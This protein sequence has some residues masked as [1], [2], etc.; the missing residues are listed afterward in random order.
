MKGIGFSLAVLALLSSVSCAHKQAEQN[1]HALNI[2]VGTYTDNNESQGVY[3]YQFDTETAESLLLDTARS[4][5]PSFIITSEDG[6]FAYAVNEYM[7]SRQGVSSFIL[8]D[9][10]VDLLNYVQ[11][12]CAGPC[13]I[14]LA[15]G[16]V[17]TA[18]YGG[19]TLSVFPVLEDGS[20]DGMS[21]QFVP[22]KTEGVKSHIHC[23]AL[24]PDGKYIFMTDLGA[25]AIY[26][27]T[28]VDGSAPR[29]FVTA[30][31]FDAL[32]H[33]GPR[34]L[35]FSQDGR[36]AYLLGEPGDCLTVFGYEEGNL[37][38][39]STQK[40]YEADGRGSADVHI[41]PDGRYV[42]TS[43]RLK[44]DGIAIFSR[45]AD[46]GTV[47][48]AGFCPTGKHPRNFAITPDGKWL[49]CA[50][51]D[52]N[53]IEIYSVDGETGQLTATG[54]TIDVPAPVCICIY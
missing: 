45:N 23:T 29:D 47:E 11:D 34:H 12:G 5:N 41:S 50:C 32:E 38:H 16:N 4:G 6:R 27:A 43:H 9:G 7:D 14:L 20:L 53:R 52:D 10:S 51:R 39:I 15:G 13:N 28:V 37:S 19:G 26:R 18:D 24:S 40:A 54:K 22:E 3:L 8:G 49:L 30:Y 33:P 1:N 21:F 36:F 2:L 42:Y 25:D 44:G 46:D 35:V 48:N 17:F 31:R